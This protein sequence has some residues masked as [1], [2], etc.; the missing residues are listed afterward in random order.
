MTSMLE[1][2]RR[3]KKVADGGTINGTY[4]KMPM[5]SLVAF[6]EDLKLLV[7]HIIGEGK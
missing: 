3:V 7:D 4:A 1:I 5:A 6:R 2:A